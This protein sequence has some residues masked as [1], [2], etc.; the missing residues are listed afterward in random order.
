MKGKIT[1]SMLSR[2]ERGELQ[3][4]YSFESISLEPSLARPVAISSFVQ[5]FLPSI[6]EV[7]LGNVRGSCVYSGLTFVAGKRTPMVRF[8][9]RSAHDAT[10]RPAMMRGTMM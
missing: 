5:F 7:P 9:D 2:K 4:H 1:I 8:W 3:R 10:V 6:S